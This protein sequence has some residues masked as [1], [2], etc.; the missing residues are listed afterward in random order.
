MNWEASA[1]AGLIVVI[2]IVATS[3]TAASA[4]TKPRSLVRI[5]SPCPEG[6][7]G[8]VGAPRHRSAANIMSSDGQES[9]AVVLIPQLNLTM[10]LNTSVRTNA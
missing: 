1:L 5:S 8:L 10:L 3:A 4:A 2:D 9:P 7:L 6:L